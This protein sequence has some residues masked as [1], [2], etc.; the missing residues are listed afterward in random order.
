MSANICSNDISVLGDI[1]EMAIS[2][3]SKNGNSG[4]SDQ[5]DVRTR[6]DGEKGHS[7]FIGTSK[8]KIPA[9]S[10]SFLPNRSIIWFSFFG[11]CFGSSGCVFA[12]AE[13]AL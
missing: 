1:W 6:T 5:N 4:F 7:T 10:V 9:N 2:D 13:T 3:V 11:F 8:G 12:D